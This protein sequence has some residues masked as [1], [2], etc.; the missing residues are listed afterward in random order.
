MHLIDPNTCQIAEI[1]A[2]TFFKLPFLP[3][4]KFS[5]LV[6]YTVMNIEPILAKDRKTFKGQGKVSHKHILA[7]C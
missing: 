2:S 5:D 7:D 3:L 6:E 4:N 1:G